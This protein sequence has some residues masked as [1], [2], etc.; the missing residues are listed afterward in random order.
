MFVCSIH[1]VLVLTSCAQCDA[2][3]RRDD[4]GPVD[5][6]EPD[7]GVRPAGFQQR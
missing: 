4:A 1:I 6:A 2:V 3:P 5:S 7:Y